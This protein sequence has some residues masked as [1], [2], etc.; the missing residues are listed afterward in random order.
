ML[1]ALKEQEL[2]GLPPSSRQNDTFAVKEGWLTASEPVILAWQT[3]VHDIPSREV[4]YQ[5]KT[6]EEKVSG[7]L[8]FAAIDLS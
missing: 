2:R 7:S 1:L 6:S 5:P 8:W 4:G 3:P